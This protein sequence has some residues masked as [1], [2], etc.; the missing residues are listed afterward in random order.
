MVNCSWRL[1]GQALIVKNLPIAKLLLVSIMMMTSFMEW[2]L[3]RIRLDICN[4]LIEFVL[5]SLRCIHKALTLQRDYHF[6]RCCSSLIH[7]L[8]AMFCSL[9]KP[10]QL[11]GLSYC[12][13][14]FPA[15]KTANEATQ[16]SINLFQL[17]FNTVSEIA[18][19]K[20]SELNEI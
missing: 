2:T 16:A 20:L 19:W 10:A 6:H 5:F 9:R 1:V 15:L 12:Y 18:V 7:V 8:Q 11:D 14:F 17:R 3:V 13:R 4:Y